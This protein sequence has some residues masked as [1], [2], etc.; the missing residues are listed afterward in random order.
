MSLVIENILG[1]GDLERERVVLRVR[2]APTDIGK[3]ALLSVR[4]DGNI[5][6]GGNIQRGYW[7]SDR[8]CAP[9]DLVVLYSKKGNRK[10]KK[11]SAGYTS[12]FF[13][14]GLEQPRWKPGT[15]A[16]LIIKMENWQTKIPID[17]DS[18][19]VSDA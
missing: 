8:E 6:R 11:N 18:D 13:Y 12:H 9:G 14:W 15:N 4:S 17:A 2:G 16:A 1:V 19:S 7:F 10:Q 5:I 3:Y